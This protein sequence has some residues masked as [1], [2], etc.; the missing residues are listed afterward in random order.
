[1]KSREDS[2]RPNHSTDSTQKLANDSCSH[3]ILKLICTSAYF[4]TCLDVL[5][6]SPGRYLRNFV[7][8]LNACFEKLIDLLHSF[9]RVLKSLL[10]R[11]S[12]EI[13]PV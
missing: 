3:M 5:K 12:E 4:M 9:E 7:I 10:P 1:M 11:F 2:I 13:F 8:V 6:R